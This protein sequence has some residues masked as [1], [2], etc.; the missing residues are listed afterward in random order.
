MWPDLR[1]CWLPHTKEYQLKHCQNWKQPNDINLGPFS[2]PRAHSYHTKQLNPWP[3]PPV[4]WCFIPGCLYVQGRRSQLN[5]TWVFIETWKALE[6]SHGKAAWIIFSTNGYLPELLVNVY[7]Y[8]VHG[9]QL[10]VK[11]SQIISCDMYLRL[12][13]KLCS[14]YCQNFSV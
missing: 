8:R 11:Y 2:T 13:L 7:S 6:T 12:T 1:K 10:F 5:T 3:T 14:T 9:N 4:V